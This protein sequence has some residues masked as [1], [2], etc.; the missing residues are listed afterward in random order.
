MK[1]KSAVFKLSVGAIFLLALMLAV[2]T[3]A[4]ETAAQPVVLTHPEVNYPVHFDIS[5]PLRDMATEVSPRMG[6]HEA[7]PVRYPKLQLLME[8]ARQGQTI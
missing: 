5:P 8:A 6:F 1:S 3:S 2:L 4:Q 7:P